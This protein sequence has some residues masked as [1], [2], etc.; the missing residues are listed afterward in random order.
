MTW[1]HRLF[2]GEIGDAELR[3]L[4]L[5]RTVTEC[6]GFSL[7][8]VE[9]GSSKSS[10]SK[11]MSDLEIRLG[12]RLCNRGR[13]GF[14]LTVEGER[15]YAATSQLFAA[16]ERFRSQVSSALEEL[17]GTL[18]LGFIDTIVTN[19][20]SCL[21]RAI[22]TYTSKYQRVRIKIISGSSEDIN[23]SILDMRL[24]VGITVMDDVPSGIESI[25]LFQEISELYCSFKHPLFDLPVS[26]L[27]QE[28]I[29]GCAFVQHGYSIAERRYVEKMGLTPKS[30]SHQTEGVLFL[31]LTGNYLGFLPTHFAALWV[32]R[33]ELRPIPGADATKRSNVKAVANRGITGSPMIKCFLDEVVAAKD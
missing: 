17:S 10:I 30:L 24:H 6:G 31:I 16:H 2:T 22:A 26:E 7:A 20:N 14:S 11:Q 19:S 1:P 3:L 32:D 13:S 9:L 28:K 12:M 8:E 27:T 5:F 18:Y 23:R 21:H 29:S 25:L 4:R 15:V 33:G